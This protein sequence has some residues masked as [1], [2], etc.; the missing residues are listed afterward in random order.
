MALD[1]SPFLRELLDVMEKE[2][3]LAFGFLLPWIPSSA[4]WTP[5]VNSQVL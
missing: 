1:L 4:S 2:N 5:L 3:T